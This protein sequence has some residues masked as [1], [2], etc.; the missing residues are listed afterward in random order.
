MILLDGD[1]NLMGTALVPT[2]A[3]TSRKY[4]T[5]YQVGVRVRKMVE[6]QAVRTC[7][8]LNSCFSRDGLRMPAMVTPRSV[9]IFSDELDI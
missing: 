8:V 4:L 2:D 7:V 6:D 9:K 3:L 1:D 5:G